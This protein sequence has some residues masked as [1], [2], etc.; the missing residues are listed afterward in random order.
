MNRRISSQR[1]IT[2]IELLLVVAIIGTLAAILIPR[3]LGALEKAKVSRAVTEI[4][5]ISLRITQ[6][7]RTND[8][9]PDSL[10]EVGPVPTVD[11]WGFD[12]VYRSSS[13]ADWNAKRRRDRWMN[14]LN[15]D[16]DLFSVGPDGDSK[17]A[18]P[19]PVS[20]DDIVRANSGSYIGLAW[21]F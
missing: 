13:A 20:H 12:Y 6:F 14:P 17:A 9:W 11:P 19:P 10:A 7:E 3:L 21:K 16:F 8:R 1:G 15:S 2:V 4:A 5:T 18:L